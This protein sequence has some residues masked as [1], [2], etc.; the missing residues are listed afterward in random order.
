MCVYVY[1]HVCGTLQRP[2]TGARSCGAVDVGGCRMTKGDA[3]KQAPVLNQSSKCP[4]QL[5]HFSSLDI[6]F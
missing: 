1:E 5:V 6:I 2:G 4:Y 3:E